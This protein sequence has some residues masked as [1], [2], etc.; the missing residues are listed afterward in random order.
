[1]EDI[2]D[3]TSA[4]SVTDK[5]YQSG[6][7]FSYVVLKIE[8]LTAALHLVTS[9]LNNSD[10]IKYKLR[11][12]AI[13]LMQTSSALKYMGQKY[14]TAVIDDLKKGADTVASFI[15][16]ALTDSSVSQMNLT[17]LQKEYRDLYNYLD[18]YQ[19]NQE[20]LIGKIDQPRISA[21]PDVSTF[22]S[23]PNYQSKTA[24]T[25][26]QFTKPISLERPLNASQNGERRKQIIGF[27]TA[28]GWSAINEIAKAAPGV[29]SKTIQRELVNLVNEG[30]LIKKGDR[31]WARYATAPRS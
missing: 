12:R 16:V 23:E 4:N 31:R 13:D 7:D 29:S 10:P 17:I 2:K 28:H 20:S 8:K 24:D 11:D 1:M 9:F 27:I 18:R 26:N 30:L 5:A 22:R 14:K 3:S 21:L 15:S 25:Q 19:I 6:V